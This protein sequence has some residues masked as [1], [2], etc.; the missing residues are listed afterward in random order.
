MPRHAAPWR[1]RL[2]QTH[3]RPRQSRAPAEAAAWNRTATHSRARRPPDRRGSLTD[4][5][6]PP[7]PP[8]AGSGPPGAVPAVHLSRRARPA[9]DRSA[10]NRPAPRAAAGPTLSPHLPARTPAPAD[11]QLT[12]RSAPAPPA[13][14]YER[15]VLAYCSTPGF[16]LD[17]VVGVVK[18]C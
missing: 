5:Q 3:R 16:V 17:G 1:A 15:S 8:Y 11:G 18:R 6:F 14:I 9:P 2:A 12:N 10:A 13:R 4:R 7:T